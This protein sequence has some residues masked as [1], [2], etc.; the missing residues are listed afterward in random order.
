MLHAL[1][2]YGVRHVPYMLSNL[3]VSHPDR[4]WHANCSYSLAG[5]NII[6]AERYGYMDARP[7]IAVT[8]GDPS[9]IGPEIAVRA[10]SDTAMYS[11]C[12]PI[13][14][15]DLDYV[16]DGV[17]MIGSNIKCKGL[18]EIGDAKFEHGTID[19]L[20]LKNVDY[21]E[22]EYG[23]V[24]AKAGHAAY[25]YIEKGIKLALAGRVDAVVTGP[26][27]KEALNL[28]GHK[29]SGHTEIF[30]DLTG[31]KDYAMML[32]DGDFRVVHV[33]THVSLREA[34]NRVKKDRV[35]TV[36]RLTD[37]ALRQLGIERPKI[38][39]AGLNPHAGEGGMF[40]TEEIDEIMP[41]IEIARSQGI[42]ADGPIP[43]DTAFA[44]ARGR[45]YDAAIAMY[46]DQGHIAMKTAGF[47]LDS[48]TGKWTAV[49]GV[50][51]TLGLPIIR[52]SVDHGTAFG[53]AGEGR[54]N[55]ESMNQA[56]RLA[57]QFAEGRSKTG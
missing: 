14:I 44:K 29:Y 48:L 42:D 13:I 22:I 55:P 38:G 1:T 11:I 19:V 21:R 33:S 16:E 4:S 37:A 52:V 51:V 30:A 27:H 35:T 36:I 50:N 47:A 20:D 39:V 54:A 26:I 46:H 6:R 25:E 56:L 10:L 7:I 5:Q 40:G 43:P 8:M 53:K 15:G 41:A 57:T 12:R 18:S 34:C 45:Q 9:G 17:T 23:K 3:H 31:T 32:A 2:L 49:S 24:S 28:G